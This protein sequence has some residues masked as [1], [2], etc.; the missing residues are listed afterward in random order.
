MHSIVVADTSCFI[1]LTKI[2]EV[3]LLKNIYSSV[4]TTPEVASEFRN[5][6]PEWV[7]VQEVKNKNVLLSLE[8][9]LDNGE[10]SAIP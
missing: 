9:E 4:Y 1:L 5:D 2:S 10:A 7:I 6:L 3:D 8:T